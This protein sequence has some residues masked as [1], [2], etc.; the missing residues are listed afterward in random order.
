MIPHTLEDQ[1]QVSCSNLIY[2]QG[3][4]F[5][6]CAINSGICV[7]TYVHWLRFLTKKTRWIR[8]T[9]TRAFI[10]VYSMFCCVLH[11]YYITGS[12]PKK[13]RKIL[14][15]I[16]HMFEPPTFLAFILNGQS[17]CKMNFFFFANAHVTLWTVNYNL[18]TKQKW[19]QPIRVRWRTHW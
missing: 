6:V 10:W 17:D 7:H 2:V 5:Y 3:V 13:K 15:I 19:A 8:V 16:C 9:P 1:G 14:Y 12:P 11:H 4:D 18:W